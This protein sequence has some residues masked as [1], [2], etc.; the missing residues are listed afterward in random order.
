MLLPAPVVAQNTAAAGPTSSDAGGF[1]GWQF[2]G[3]IG[4]TF[5]GTPT[6]TGTLPRGRSPRLETVEAG[7]RD[8]RQGAHVRDDD[9][10]VLDVHRVAADLGLT[11]L[12]IHVPLPNEAEAA[13]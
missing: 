2:E 8:P 9:R 10:G 11:T 5:A 7:P 12:G 1:H 13:R 4:G 6:G 3:H